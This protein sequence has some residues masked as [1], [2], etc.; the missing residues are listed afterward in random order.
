MS[1]SQLQQAVQSLQDGLHRASE[2][3]D[4]KLVRSL[5][6]NTFLCSAKCCDKSTSRADLQQW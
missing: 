1:E 2:I 5:Q 6:K 3:I 4:S